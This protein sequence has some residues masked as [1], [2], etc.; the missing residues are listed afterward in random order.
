V[1]RHTEL[2]VRAA[3]VARLRERK[4]AGQ[5]AS[6]EV[7]AAA[8]GLAVSERTVWRWIA[9]DDPAR[10]GRRP[11]ARYEITE[12]DW[13]GNIAALHRARLAAGEEGVPARHIADVLGVQSR[14]QPRC[15]GTST[16]AGRAQGHPS[17]RERSLTGRLVGQIG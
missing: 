13:R 7:R 10:T 16:E 6:A 8:A 3:L 11:R 4:A 2:E 17:G 12:A 1:R 9:G 14:V 5:L 15:N